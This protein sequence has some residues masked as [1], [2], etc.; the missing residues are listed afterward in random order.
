MAKATVTSKGQ[1]TIPL[2]IRQK[3][4]LEPGTVLEFDEGSE[5]LAATKAVDRK[6]MR[7]V[8]GIAADVLDAKAAS[9]WLDE[10]RGPAALPVRRPRR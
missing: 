4:A 6:R 8:I 5:S 9:E 2:V 3:L 10:L 7:A 1:I